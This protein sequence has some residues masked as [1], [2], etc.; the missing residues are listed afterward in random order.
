M[1]TGTS[2]QSFFSALVSP[3]FEELLAVFAEEDEQLGDEVGLL[4]DHA[5]EVVE[6]ELFLD[7]VGVEHQHF[8]DDL[9]SPR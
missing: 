7:G 9:L 5:A 8:L 3:L 1:P 2:S 4:V 6:E